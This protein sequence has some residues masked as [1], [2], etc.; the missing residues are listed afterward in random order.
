MCPPSYLLIS[1]RPMQA[2]GSTFGLDNSSTNLC[3]EKVDKKLHLFGL[4]GVG[5]GGAA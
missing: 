2:T 3:G 4:R 5:G 1:R